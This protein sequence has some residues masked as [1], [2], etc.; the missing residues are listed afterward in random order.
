VTSTNRER[1]DHL[2]E[3]VKSVDQ[4]IS[5]AIC[6]ASRLT[7]KPQER[8]K[9]TTIPGMRAKL[10][11]LRKELSQ[12]ADKEAFISPGTAELWM[13]DKRVISLRAKG[14]CWRK[15]GERLDRK[16]EHLRYRY[17]QLHDGPRKRA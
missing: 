4:G 1:L 13:L 15:I 5:D 9:R 11:D 14:L 10:A 8:L 3:E 17:K 7:G 6:L 12:R 16:S 2:I